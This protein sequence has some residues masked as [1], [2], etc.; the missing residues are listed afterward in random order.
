MWVIEPFFW[1]WLIQ[2]E[3][4]DLIQIDLDL[5][6]INSWLMIGLMGCF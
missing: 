4:D 6:V 1:E 5:N 3:F 2:I